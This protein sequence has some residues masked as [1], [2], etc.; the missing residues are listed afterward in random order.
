[1]EGHWG[2]TVPARHPAVRVHYLPERR[3]K[4]GNPRPEVG[5]HPGAGEDGCGKGQGVSIGSKRVIEEVSWVQA[6]QNPGLYS[7]L[8]C[9]PKRTLEGQRAVID[10][11]RFNEFVEKKSFRMSSI[12]EVRCSV[13]RG[14]FGTTIDLEDA[15][16]HIPLHPESRKYTRFILDGTV[17]QF[18]CLPMG[19]TLSPRVFTELTKVLMRHLRKKGMIVI[20]YLDDLLVLSNSRKLS[21]RDTQGVLALL[22]TLGFS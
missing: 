15:F 3:P 19:L 13:T 5:H 7:R 20:I 10:L 21:E 12:K 1:M 4:P 8:F 16:Y 2:P 9:V 22:V 14:S 11:S 18:T 17:W 6:E